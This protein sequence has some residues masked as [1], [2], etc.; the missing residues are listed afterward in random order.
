[1]AT[2]FTADG[3]QLASGEILPLYA[4]EFHY[5]R[6]ERT[7]WRE[8]LQ[9]LK[10]LGLQVISTAVPWSVHE[11]AP[12]DFDF[13]GNLDLGAFLDEVHDLGLY[14]LVRPGPHCNDQLT[15]FGFP[16][17]VLADKAVQARSARGTALWLPAPPKM[18]PVPSYASSKFQEEV[19]G[20]FAALG[21]VVA[22]RAHPQG[23][24]VAL[25]LDNE[26]HMFWRVGAFEGDYHPEAL[27][28][29]K[30]FSGGREAPNHYEADDMPRCLRWLAFKEEYLR[31][32]FVWLREAAEEA[33]MGALARYHN[34][35][36][37]KPNL[38]NQPMVEEAIEGI[39]GM[40]FH[41]LTADYARVR[42]RAIYLSGSSLLP[43]APE[44]RIGGAGWMP[45]MTDED[46]KNVILGA[47]AGGLRAFNL[48][49]A[50]ERERWHGGLLD[51]RGRLRDSAEWI[52]GLLQTLGDVDFHTLRRKTPIALVVSRAEARAAVASCAVDAATH[53]VTDWMGLGPGG[54]AELAMDEDARLY[55]R[56]QAA[57]RQALDLAEIPYQL[58]DENCLHTIDADTRAV[59]LPTLRRVDGG[60]W[61]A[62]HTLSATGMRVVI[63]PELPREDELGQELGADSAK[64][65]GAGL[66]AAEF[67]DDTDELAAALLDLAGELGELW[68]AP[69]SESVDCSLFSDD[70]G[71]P[72][73][74]FA[75]NRN[76]AAQ[77]VSV[78]LPE[79]CLLRDALTGAEVR[80]D[81]GVG[82]IS[83]GGKQVRM[84]L[85]AT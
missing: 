68:I 72:R 10:D 65:K 76:A 36:A 77:E 56:W 31:R 52:A 34:L 7:L 5:W 22:P 43:F 9:A 69:E 55:P 42:E 27:A 23:S 82:A 13:T 50:V 73:V 59:L 20:W 37:S 74:L 8:S 80:E 70:T 29:W 83:L 1:M 63:G 33:G 58:I 28:W 39:A 3:I 4:G 19:R 41:D 32:S 15:H 49:M 44:L 66:I 71:A 26:M 12:G 45:V 57:V 35:P 47:L 78:N 11:R 62:L 79:G 85:I 16:Q 2:R 67:L 75:G 21:E 51:D 60:A 53:A 40:D 81:A 18:F 38:C 30:D 84:F 14:A 48:Y 24:A 61:A 64:P 54:H 6:C 46:Q 17:R 25:Q